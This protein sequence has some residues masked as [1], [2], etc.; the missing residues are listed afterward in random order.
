M[1]ITM[2]YCYVTVT[3]YLFSGKQHQFVTLR[4]KNDIFCSS[5]GSSNREPLLR[6]CSSNSPA[7]LRYGDEGFIKLRY[8]IT[9]Q[10]FELSLSRL[11]PHWQGIF[12][13]TGTSHPHYPVKLLA[14]RH[15]TTPNG[16]SKHFALTWTGWTSVSRGIPLA[17]LLQDRS[18]EPSRASF[19]ELKYE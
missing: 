1:S 13:T 5:F 2:E 9:M 8:W 16:L 17:K 18:P 7:V 19:A 10:R 15:T 14:S 6:Y 11:C 4:R 12:V 3:I